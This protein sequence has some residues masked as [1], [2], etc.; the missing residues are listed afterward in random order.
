MSVDFS[1]SL[2]YF[3]I[4]IRKHLEFINADINLNIKNNEGF[5]KNSN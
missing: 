4:T 1:F 3:E 2:F 5:L